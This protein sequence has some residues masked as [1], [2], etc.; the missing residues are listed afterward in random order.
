MP[1]GFDK[2]IVSGASTR[3]TR[4]LGPEA[5]GEPPPASITTRE[6][7]ARHH[8]DALLK[9]DN[10][11]ALR[12]LSIAAPAA[13]PDTEPVPDLVVRGQDH[14]D[15]TGTD[16]VFFEQ[17]RNSIPVF[18][19]RA[20]VELD[21]DR[22]LVSA[23]V[24]VADVG[25][26]PEEARLT[27]DD[28]RARLDAYLAGAADLTALAPPERAYLHHPTRETWHLTWRFRNVPAAPPRREDEQP[29]PADALQAGCC[30][31]G[32][33]H[34]QP[35]YDYFID[36]DNGDLVY[37]FSNTAHIDIPT[38][39]SGEDEDGQ[40]Q[41]FFGRTLG[42][43]FELH[44][45]FEQIR[46]YD[47]GLNAIENTPTPTVP[48]QNATNDWAGSNP[49]AISAHVNATRVLDFLYRVLRRKS[50]D[51]LGMSLDNV[52]NC[53]S[54]EAPNPPEWLNAVWWNNKMWYGQES[55]GSGGYRSLSRFLDIIA[56]ELT[57][58]VTQYTANLVYQ[59][60]PGALN[61]SVSDIFG[62]I[63]SNWHL[64]PNPSDVASWSWEIGPGLGVGGNPMRHMADPGRVGSWYKPDASGNWQ[65]V[66]GYPA[67][68]N[69]YVALPSRY[70]NGGVH[71]FSNI[72]NRA[73]HGV[74]TA[75]RPDGTRV[76]TPEEVAILY[77]LSLSRLTQLS[78]F[79]DM[80]TELRN[81]VDTAYAGSA[82]RLAEA[83]QA[84]DDAYANVGIV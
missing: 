84:V 31:V 63:V 7:A 23:S 14:K 32:S 47:M 11:A 64:A 83:Q 22:N 6:S 62:V 72:H 44:N 46:T 19:S 24:N 75:Q 18:G 8:L 74:L 2:L 36:A 5:A 81:V 43:Q 67:H 34:F 68:M 69:D 35:D 59:D 51:D 71:I 25:D 15:L 12:G 55:D 61:E 82:T 52:V 45:P 41:R 29:L 1:R 26:A 54:T 53:Y 21:P 73:A 9:R 66:Q 28:A 58:G 30:G 38:W 57:H 20:V 10:R 80:R 33:P 39:C 70:D 77:Y 40:N 3:R 76:F 42:G 50:I 17:T 27:A 4:G 78:D 79:S 37:S 16:F 49:A 60:L 56:H 13:A 48:I 65:P